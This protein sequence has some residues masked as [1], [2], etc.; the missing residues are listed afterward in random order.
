MTAWANAIPSRDALHEAKRVALLRE[1]A[2]A[3]TRRGFHAASLDDIAQKL[4]VTKAALYHYFPSKHALLRECFAQALAL[5]FEGLRRAEETGANGREKLRLTLDFYLNG[6]ID[7]LSCATVLM[8]E[9]ALLP[10]DYAAILKERDRF[11]NGLR[12]LIRAGIADGSIAPCDPKLTV[13]A[14][15]GAINWVPKWFRR[16]GA[17]SADQVS[18]ALTDL[19]DRMVSATPV[20]AL[21]E[22]IAAGAK[23]SKR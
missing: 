2:S 18:A 20:A 10:D 16:N 19:L 6:M 5:G 17:W 22:D 8:E 23:R 7:E 13:F 1:A 11:E 4:G 12:D 15:L 21:P 3:F 9:N 14:L